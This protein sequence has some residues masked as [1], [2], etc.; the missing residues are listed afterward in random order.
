[1]DKNKKALVIGG[2]GFLGSHL[3]ETLNDKGYKVTILDKQKIKLNRKIK[4][5]KGD[6]K[7]NKKL[8]KVIKGI[9][10]V[11]FLAG[12]GDIQEC[13]DNPIQTIS[14]NIVTVLNVMHCCKKNKIKRFIFAS[15]IYVHSSQGSFYRV[16]KQSAELY[17]EEFSKKHN[18]KYTILRYGTV[19]GPRS[20]MRN[21]IFSIISNAIKL[22]KVIYRGTKKSIRRFVHVKDA[23]FA[24]V[25]ILKKKFQNKKVVITGNSKT[26]L[27]GFLE[28]LRKKMN[29][30]K[31][32]IYQNKSA[33]HYEVNPY[34]ATS[35]K[36]I[37]YDFKKNISFK[38][39]IKELTKTI[40][41][42]IK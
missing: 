24:S 29:I 32:V 37:R 41:K 1:M 16:S 20:D 5:I 28:S 39:G 18:L 10:Y 27:S 42:N 19:Y 15:T 34:I 7:D 11:Y 8:E 9:N 25:D 23:S 13:M 22:K 30:N 6:I 31:E 40:E 35:G 33:G 2:S 14:Q 21:N 36:E 38:E 12:M 3:A 26:K 17:I 4:F